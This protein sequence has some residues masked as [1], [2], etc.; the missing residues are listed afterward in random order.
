MG[1]LFSLIFI[2][3]KTGIELTC[4]IVLVLGIQRNGML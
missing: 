1:F 4:D 3:L 2:F